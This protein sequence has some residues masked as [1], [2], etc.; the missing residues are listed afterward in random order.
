MFFDIS[1]KKSFLNNFQF[2]FVSVWRL[3][4]FVISKQVFND[5]KRFGT[6]FVKK[7]DFFVK[8][9]CFAVWS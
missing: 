1:S 9:F 5:L 2:F 3:D 6:A 4:G 8:K 7:M